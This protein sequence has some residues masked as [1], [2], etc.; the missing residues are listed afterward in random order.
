MKRVTT[1]SQSTTNSYSRV[2]SDL[3]KTIDK[4]QKH[5]SQPGIVTNYLSNKS[6]LVT[7]MMMQR[8]RCCGTC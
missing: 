7:G 2:P 3:F 4:L 6:V 1:I 8:T 5:T